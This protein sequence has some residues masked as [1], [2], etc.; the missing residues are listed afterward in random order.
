MATPEQQDDDNKP[1]EGASGGETKPAGGAAEPASGEDS[2]KPAAADGA[3]KKPAAG[4]GSSGGDA[5]KPSPQEQPNPLA[6]VREG[7]EAAKAGT[8]QVFIWAGASILGL[9]GVMITSLLAGTHPTHALVTFGLA[10]LAVGAATWLAAKNPWNFQIQRD[11]RLIQ[12]PLD[13]D[14]LNTVYGRLQSV[15]ATA[16]AV[17]LKQKPEIGNKDKVRANIFLADYRRAPDGVGCELRMPAQFRLNMVDPAEWDLVFQPGQGATGEVFAT[18][19]PVL[20]IDRM[21][22]VPP[23]LRDVFDKKITPGLRAIISLPISNSEKTNVIA[24]VNIDLCDPGSAYAISYD[25]LNKVY[26]AI[27]M[28]N[29]NSL[30]ALEDELNKLDKVLL[31]IALRNA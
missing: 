30:A 18:R 10:I 21:Y 27:R 1:V 29:P 23:N 12:Q 24:V 19:Q 11:W 6:F 31:T 20:T 7:L 17:F 28:E 4:A 13:G 25:D 26:D 8:P 5:D 15:R 2:T 22:G 9:A 14:K 3:G 16:A